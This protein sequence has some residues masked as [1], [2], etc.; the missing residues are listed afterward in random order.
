MAH[1]ISFVL[2]LAIVLCLA[3]FRAEAEDLGYRG[4]GPRVGV[5]DDPD[6]ILGGLQ[7]D[8][9][10]FARHVRWQPSVEVGFGDDVNALLGNFMVS[11]YFPIEGDLTPYVGGE[12]TVAFLDFDRGGSDTEIG[13]A[14]VGGI[15][16]AFA[17]G[18]RFLLELQLGFGDI[19]DTRLMAGWTFR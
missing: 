14:G 19:P 15:E 10:E 2:I 16:V 13:P 1:R 9:G 11:Y 3:P 12:V 8:L 7:F 17:G 4:W 6:Q 5:S 18:T